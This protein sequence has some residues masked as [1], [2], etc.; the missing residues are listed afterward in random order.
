VVA[1]GGPGHGRLHAGPAG[2]RPRRGRADQERT[3]TVAVN[4]KKL[5]TW[6]VV[7]LVAYL[8]IG[9]PIESANAVHQVLDWVRQ[10]AEALITFVRSVFT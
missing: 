5:V 1:C 6:I 3:E 7:A 10:G 9:R 4:A 2:R 8:L